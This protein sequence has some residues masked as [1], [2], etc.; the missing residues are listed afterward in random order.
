[1]GYYSVLKI[2]GGA[3]YIS[4]PL[5][6]GAFLFEGNE[7]ALLLD[8]CNGFMDIRKT[9]NKL[10]D[11]PL[12]VVNS[13][14][15]ADHAGGNPQFE[16]VYIHTGDVKMLDKTW[17]KSQ[18]DMLFGYVKEHYP[19]LRPVL[20]VLGNQKFK[21]FDTQVKTIDNNHA[22]DLGGRKLNVIHLAGHSPGSIMLT[23]ER[24]KTLYAGDAVN[25]GMFLFFDGS[26]PLSVYAARLR[27]LTKLK[28]L[29]FIR[30][31]HSKEPLPF[32]FIDYYANFLERV[33]LEKSTLTDIPN[34]RGAVYKYSEEG[35]KFCSNFCSQFCLKEICVHYTKRELEG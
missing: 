21:T 34:E 17:Q 23:D 31:S 2:G 5:G 12:T 20:W 15:H 9:L 6:V 26:P 11:K 32:S 28:G 3:W 10:T 16:S 1:M 8:T 18:R 33:T 25:A 22:F 19:L 29:D 14:G 7:A 35:S 13:H 27:E 24:T 4:E 30:I